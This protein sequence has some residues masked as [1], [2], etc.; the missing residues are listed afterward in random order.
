MVSEGVWRAAKIGVRAWGPVPTLLIALLATVLCGPV[1]A[2]AETGFA[3]LQIQPADH[4]ARLALGV[5]GASGG[6]LV[7]DIAPGGPGEAAGLERGDLL[8]SYEGVGLAGMTQLVTFMQGTRP[9]DS[10]D[11]VVRR[12]GVDRAVSLPLSA[13]PAGWQIANAATA[14]APGFGATM[15]ALTSDVRTTHGVRWGRVGV[16]VAKV[17]EES[18]ATKA[19]LIAGDLL[20]A[21]GRTMVSDPAQ[22]EPLL[23][24]AG[25]KWTA[26]IERAAVVMLLGPGRPADVAPVA[27]QGLL[28]AALPDGPYVLDVVV[29]GPDGVQPGASLAKMPAADSW[30]AA[31]EREVPNAGLRVATLSEQARAQWPVRWS[32]Q[33]VVVVAV[34]PGTRGSLAGLRPGHVIRSINQQPVKSLNDIAALDDESGTVMVVAEDAAGFTILTV[35]PRGGLPQASPAQ[36]PLLQWQAPKGG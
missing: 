32:A 35:E 21:V 14:V 4:A 28:A 8:L 17:A 30:P 25:P 23:N 11:L 13:W 34:E 5:E 6:V 26:L 27:G 20:I 3:G 9:G 29:E 19:G 36:R 10:I 18:P 31:A 16:L 22:V 15:V 2:S 1:S 33:G 7:R 24:A 12:N